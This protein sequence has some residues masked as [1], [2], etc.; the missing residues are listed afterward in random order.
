MNSRMSYSKYDKNALATKSL[1]YSGHF[2]A[3]SNAV[4]ENLEKGHGVL[5]EKISLMNGFIPGR[6][7][8]PRKESTGEFLI[9]GCGMLIY[10]KGFDL[11]LRDR[12][13]PDQ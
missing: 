2:I 4:K 8:L 9:G 13:D 7:S 1:K 12:R 5:P 3:V 11:F 10:R 6:P